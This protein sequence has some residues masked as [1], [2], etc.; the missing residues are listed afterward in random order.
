MKLFVLTVILA[1][2]VAA[3]GVAKMGVYPGY[4]PGLRV[5]G[6]VVV[7]QRDTYTLTLTY[8]LTGL[9][10][11]SGGIHIH[12][13]TDCKV[14]A[15]PHLWK[16]KSVA[17]PWNAI[18]WSSDDEYA[19]TINIA[20]VG[21]SAQEVTTAG[22]VIVVHDSSG[23]RVACGKLV[24]GST[25]G[26]FAL[27]D[28]YPSYNGAIVS[29]GCVDVTFQ[30]PN[31]K[32]D[33][34]LTGVSKSTEGGVHIHT[35]LN[36]YDASSVGGHYYTTDD[37][38]W[39]TTKWASD[40]TQSARGA[41]EV[42]AG[43]TMKNAAGHA[44]VVHDGSDKVGCGVLASQASMSTLPG[45]GGPVKTLGFVRVEPKSANQ[46][47]VSYTLYGVDTA[48]TGQVHVHVGTDCS[49]VGGHYYDKTKVAVDPWSKDNC[50]VNSIG[51]TGVAM[52]SFDIT[53]GVPIGDNFGRTIVVHDAAGNKVACGVLSGVY[54]TV[55]AATLEPKDCAKFSDWCGSNNKWMIDN[56]E[57]TCK[58]VKPADSCQKWV[59]YCNKGNQ[60]MDRNC[61]ATCSGTTSASMTC[62][63]AL[64]FVESQKC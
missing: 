46:L 8:D 12:E 63:S 40:N 11:T 52:G 17:D 60:W 21:Y 10:G 23:T 37:D 9:V 30:D 26:H 64:D 14:A 45:Y 16:D 24:D 33:Y 5:A 22:R 4:Q 62:K 27:I 49:N 3:E 53:T 6:Q 13:G 29:K 59:M 42:E 34:D 36:C 7:S 48:G 38:G 58:A 31:I 25:F 18:K 2:Y 15:G 56:C 28:R 32:L 35:G 1:T 61:Q 39:K 19:G 51:D 20:D 50:P 43:I 55:T 57:N 41:A 54:S 44:V 47:T